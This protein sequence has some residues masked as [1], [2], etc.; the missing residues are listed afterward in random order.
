MLRN[1]L[2]ILA[3]NLFFAAANIVPNALILKEKRFRFAAMRSLTVQIAGGT[4]AIAAAYA[5]AGIYALTINPVFSSLMLL[6]INYRQNPLPLRL[7]PGRKALGKVFSFSAYQFSFQLIN[8]F[9]RNLDKLLMGRYMSL[10]QLGYYDKSYRLMMLPLQ[11]IA[12][13]ISPVMHPI[14]RRCSTT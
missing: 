14:F 5:G 8:Y 10:S 7:R 3:L 6:A 13:V 2:R 11:N 1:V 4:A 12:Y 9:S